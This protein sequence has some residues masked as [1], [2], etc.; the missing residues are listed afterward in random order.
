MIL[1]L[2]L[3]DP[4]GMAGRHACA[5][6]EL[7]GAELSVADESIARFERSCW[8]RRHGQPLLDIVLTAAPNGVVAEL[9]LTDSGRVHVADDEGFTFTNGTLILS[10]RPWFAAL[11]DRETQLATLAEDGCW[12][13][14][15]VS[16]PVVHI[17][18][19]ARPDVE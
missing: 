3:V 18:F 15:G 12:R 2:T 10:G 6:V 4:S 17:A 5:R 1:E 19:S 14:K 11:S 13:V 9:S 7:V 8:R 16:A